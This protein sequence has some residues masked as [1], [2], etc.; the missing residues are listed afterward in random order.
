MRTCDVIYDTINDL[1]LEQL[2][3]SCDERCLIVPGNDQCPFWCWL[4][5]AD[6]WDGKG[7]SLVLRLV[8]RNEVTALVPITWRMVTE[9]YK[10][11]KWMEMNV[12]ATPM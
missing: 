12:P 9:I 8:A 6:R 7:R 10:G 11:D 5:Q 3:I 4:P 1:A 2:N